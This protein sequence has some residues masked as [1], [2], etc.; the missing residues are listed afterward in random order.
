MIPQCHRR[1]QTISIPEFVGVGYRNTEGKSNKAEKWKE[2]R[3]ISKRNL[4]QAE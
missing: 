3:T 1:S 4:P 2:R